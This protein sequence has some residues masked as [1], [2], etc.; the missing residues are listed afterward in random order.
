LRINHQHTF[1]RHYGTVESAKKHADGMSK[2]LFNFKDKF[3][4]ADSELF[5]KDR[6]ASMKHHY[7]REISKV[8]NLPIENNRSP[9]TLRMYNYLTNFPSKLLPFITINQ[10][11]VHQIDLRTS[12]PLLFANILNIYLN[13]TWEPMQFGDKK[14]KGEKHLLELFKKSQTRKYLKRL[15]AILRNY[16]KQLPSK[17]LDINHESPILLSG[18]DNDVLHFLNNVFYQDFYGVLQQQMDLPSRGAAKLFMFKLIFGS[19]ARRDMYMEKFKKSYPTITQLIQEFK[20]DDEKSSGK[21]NKSQDTNFSVFMQCVES[22][23]YID[24][25]YKPL[26]K[27]GVDCFSRHDSIVVV[28]GQE[29]TVKDFIKKVFSE[30]EFVYNYKEE[31]KLF[32]AY[33]G[34]EL[35][36]DFDFYDE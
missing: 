28:S 30:I 4:V 9:L 22:E 36:I 1:D 8:G 33:T 6:V 21:K 32:E 18:D 14:D 10:N 26:R 3:Y 25:I 11:T 16:H 31:D 24:R 23:I 35:R 2:Q 27:Q 29:I 17:G 13:K 7:H 34:D 15:F 5:L 19:G 20:T 12:Q